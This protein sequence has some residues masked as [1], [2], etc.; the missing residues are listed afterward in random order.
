[1]M[2]CNK[3][4]ASRAKY[5]AEIKLQEADFVGAKR[6]ALKAHQL[7]P[8]L[9]NIS[10]LLAVC[11]VHCCAA[12]KIN[13]ETDWYG[14]LQLE[15][16]ADDMALKKQY[17]KLALLLHPDKNKFAGAEAA[18]KL[19]GEAHM[20]L[21]DQV[22][23]LLYDKKRK[24]VFATSTPLPKKRGRPPKKT[25]PVAKRANKENIDAADRQKEPQQAGCF[26]GYSTFWTICLTCGTKYQYPC[27]LLMKILLCR[28]CSRSFLAYD[29]SKK[30]DPVRGETSYPWSGF[31]MQQKK[32][33]PSQQAHVTNQQHV[34]GWQSPFTCHQTHATH[35][36]QQSRNGPHQQTTAANQQQQQSQKLLFNAGSMNSVN[37]QRAG[38]PNNK[39]TG[40]NKVTAKAETCNS[41]KVSMAALKE[42][43]CEGR[44]EPSL[45]S[46]DKVPPANMQKRGR[47]VFTGS[48]YSNNNGTEGNNVTAKARTCNST[49]VSIAAL[50]EENCAGRTEPPLVSADKVPPANIQKRVREAFTGSSYPVAMD[51]SQVTTNDVLTVAS[52]DKTARQNSQRSSQQENNVVSED[53]HGGCRE[54][55]DHPL[56]SHVE[57]RIRIGHS[58]CNA[59]KSGETIN[60]GANVYNQQRCSIPSTQKTPNENGEVINVLD[61]DEKQGTSKKEEMPSSGSDD[62]ARSVDNSIPCKFT[63][64]C[65]DS[66]FYDFEKNRDAYRFKVDQIWAI[67]DDHDCMPRYYA[68]IKQVYSPNFMLRFAWLE[69]DPLNDAEKA[70]SSKE[71]PV[72]CGSFRIGRTILTED[73]K[74]FSHVI[75]W[76][77]GRK[78][79]N[80]EIY[81]RKGEVWALFKGW[82]INWSSDSNDHKHNNYDVVE[83]KSDFAVDTGTYVIRLVKVNGFV[84]LFVRSSNEEPYLIPGGDTLRFSHSIPFHRL[85]DTDSQHIPHGALELDPASLPSD[86]EEAFSSVELNHSFMSTQEGYTGFNVS[87]TRNSCNGEMLAGRTKQG[88][89]GAAT[90]EE[91]VHNGVKKP[92]PNP[93]SEQDKGSEASVIDAHSADE[94]DDSSQPEFPTNFDY[95]D[96]Q[97]CNFTD[98]RSFD[99]FKNG[100]IWALY[101]DADKFPKYY[102]FVKRVDPDDCT[103]H[104]RWLEYCPCAETEKRLLQEGLPVGCGIFKVSRQSDSYDCTSVFSHIMEVSPISEGKKYEILPRVGQVWAIYKN[105]SCGW[106]FKNI[107]SCEYDLVEVLEISNDSITV[108]C[109]TKVEGFITVFMPESTGETRSA[110]KIPKSDMIMF[111]HQIPAY[112]LTN[113]DDKLCGYWELDPASVPE[114][115]LVRKS[116]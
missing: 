78:R 45:V 38:D 35:K 97:F 47:K 30:P 49:K 110:M 112:R 67:Y 23:R 75:S 3:E 94:W 52:A 42:E 4:E 33:P 103:I 111:S 64:S 18:F 17:R 56:D 89:N 86:L 24:S 1:M 83:V 93:D 71:L 2:E 114:I 98:I 62:A 108:S 107:K 61:H 72:A 92:N 37:S 29:L 41:T 44:I 95:P 34:P 53:G 8:G 69:L 15:A 87:S 101:C 88:T 59:G 79:N 31:G 6:M 96:P 80:Y 54:G 43:N 91:N 11:E 40:G 76:A 73:T 13:G 32:F 84:S 116:K 12:V 48:N 5:L 109:L 55:G 20:T 82:D 85:A 27:S 58:C 21:T 77:K 46:A 90:N 19:I 50:K 9:E 115:F 60:E 26:A 7:F 57:K 25:D 65:P 36:Q 68:R 39:E 105:W 106:S 74:M 66:N 63:V 70:W 10:R 28:I 104:V 16:T 102:G 14:I 113:E 51:G 22:K 99:N 100:Q 81:P